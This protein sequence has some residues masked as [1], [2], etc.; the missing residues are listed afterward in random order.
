M[1]VDRVGDSDAC[2]LERQSGGLSRRVCWWAALRLVIQELV[3]EA[4]VKTGADTATEC[5]R[6]T[7]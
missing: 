6:L 3:R 7:V 4:E 1:A 2:V 5:D